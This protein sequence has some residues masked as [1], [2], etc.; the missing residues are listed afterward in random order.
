MLLKD[1]LTT[2][3]KAV[4]LMFFDK[5]DKLQCYEYIKINFKNI[6]RHLLEMEVM[7][8]VEESDCDEIWIA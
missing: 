4:S 7:E 1:L 3:K 6:P 5:H 8:V 2:Q